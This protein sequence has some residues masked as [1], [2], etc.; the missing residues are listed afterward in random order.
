M[1]D[2]KNQLQRT[3][4][5]SYTLERELE[6]GGMARVF[7][8]RDEGLGRQVVV[9]TLADDSGVS[10]SAERFRREIRLAASLQ[11]ANIVPVHSA[12]DVDGVPYYTMPFVEGESLRAHMDKR[13]ALEVRE[14]VN[15]LRDVAR[16][17]AFAHER[18]VVHR[19]IKP[20]NILLSGSTAVVTDFGI[21]KAIEAS[22]SL[23][24]ATTLTQLGTLLGTPAYISPE[25]AA[26]D[27][28]IDHLVDIYSLGVVAYEMLAG[29]RPFA[30]TAAR[31]LLAA[32]VNEPPPP[33]AS[34]REGLPPRLASLV[35][36][37]LEK[38]PGRRPQKAEELLEALEGAL[39]AGAASS[40]SIPSIAVLPFAN[41][42]PDPADE[43]FADGLTDEIITDLSGIKSLRVIARTA[44][45]R[46][47]GTEKEPAVIAR[48]LRVRYV[49]D[50]SVRRAGNSMRLTARLLDTDTDAIVWSDKLSGNVEDVFE[51]Q[52]RVSRTIVDALKLKLS[53][54]EERH[55][56]E[57]PFEDLP[58]YQAYLQAKQAMW[59]F[60]P[61][62]LKRARE[63]LEYA[64]SRVGDN[65][66]LISALG[67]VAIHLISA[68][69]AD[70]AE[71]VARADA[72]AK[73]LARLAPDSFG[74]F[75]LQGLLHWRNGE[76]REAIST[77]TSAH[78]REPSNVDV[79]AYLEY[80]HLLA[81]RDDRARE[82]G[83]LVIALDPVTPLMQVMPT[84]CDLMAGKADQ[85]L[86][87]Y[88]EFASLEPLNPLAQ[89]WL[90]SI[91]AEGGDMRGMR[92]C[93]ID[94]RTRWPDSEF[95]LAAKLTLEILD[96]PDRATTITVPSAVRTLSSESE[97][98]SRSLTWLFGR[99]GAHDAA[100]DALEDC[101]GRG[102]AH[103]PHLA[104]DAKSLSGVRGHPRFQR[105]LS[106][107]RERWERGGTSA[108]DL[109]REQAAHAAQAAPAAPT[110]TA[111]PSIA[112]L[113]FA[114]LSPDRADEFFADGLTDEIITD[115]SGIKS[116][117]VIARSAMMRFKATE[118]E[119]AAIAREL[120]VRYVLDGS[121]RR[122]GDSMRLTARLLD[123]DTDTIVWSDKLNGK[124]E[125]VFE[126]QERVSRTIVTA[127]KVT[128]SPREERHIAERPI[129]DLQAYDA[130]LQARQLMWTF[131]TE[132]L[133]RA[134]QLLDAAHA[135]IGENPRLLAALGNLHLNYI[136]TGARDAAMHL[137]EAWKYGDRVAQ[138]EPDSFAA[139]A[140]LGGL[141]WRTGR[142]REAIVS[143]RRARE[144]EPNSVDICAFLTYA[145]LLAG[146]DDRA[147]ELSETLTKLDP[148]TPLFQVM[149]G[150]CDTMV[151]NPDA[152]V[153]YY[154]RFVEADPQSPVP[155][156]FYLSV[157]SETDDTDTTLAAAERLAREF[158]ETPFGR[159][160][161]AYARAIRGERLP[162]TDLIT[163]EIRA[164]TASSDAFA[165]PFGVLLARMGEH[166]A[167]IDALEC[168]VRLGLAH[169]PYLARNCRALEPLRS[170]PR[171][172]ALLDVVRGRWER[173]GTSA[174]D[175][176]APVASA[177][178][179]A[180]K[181]VIAVLPFANLSPDPENEFFAD[182]I[183]DD[184]IAQVAKI[185]SLRVIART[186]VMRY[187]G[188]H[189]AARTA[190]KELGV[191]AVVEGTVRRAGKRA[192]IVAQLIDAS[193]NAP[194]WSETYDRDLDDVFTVQTEVATSVA[195]ALKVNL[196]PA[197]ERRIAR[198]PTSDAKAYDLY[199]IG[200]HLFNRRTPESLR[201][202]IAQFEQAIERDPRFAAA[203]AG[204]ADAYTFAGLGYAPVPIL[205]AFASAKS[206][207]DR[208]LALDDASPEAQC[209]TGLSA[210]H[211][212]W[213][214]VRARAAFE[215]AVAL[216]PSHAAAHQMLG[217][218]TFAVGEYAAALEPLGRARELDPLNV[219]LVVEE[220]WPYMYGGLHAIGLELCRRAVTLD[221]GFGL[222]HYNVG[223]CLEALGRHAE[224]LA[225]FER[226][227]ECMGPSPWMLAS[228]GT[229]SVA[230]GNP[231]RA[232]EVLAT[233][234]EQGRAGV[235][236][237]L[238]IA[239]VHDALGEAQPG[240]DALERSIEAHEP[241]V[242]AL[243]LENWLKFPNVRK[244]PG[245]SRLYERVGS[246]PHNIA[247]QRE[248]LLAHA[249]QQGLA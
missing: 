52:E 115:L 11:Q 195:A 246:K 33:L 73:K 210:M 169:Y 158:P 204:L 136:E 143:L 186:S 105:I 238:S 101:V 113:P 59:S 108:E 141:Q 118:K 148:I 235:A 166:D 249:K 153:P 187:R 191:S 54:R 62:S 223:N 10:V 177:P 76:V 144:L 3:L 31:A 240:L 53:P 6:G 47:K 114:N 39:L 22:H 201:G 194:I 15:I 206:A 219:S 110:A 2:L 193:S 200:R 218:C 104:R 122:A 13:G 57:R 208:A 9:K 1:S 159:A 128:L 182:G 216:N 174:E 16:A 19:D 87:K 224:A 190:A 90:L 60:G 5:D 86:D 156:Y 103:Y 81:G 55:L 93:A 198:S 199:L 18:G 214:V 72:S 165:R 170:L 45:M 78:E 157:L 127:L 38:D 48:E 25:Q 23:A 130:Y 34:K 116:L 184:L 202:A 167:A 89:F 145:Y 7:V 51:M 151:G 4:G 46:F 137:A 85:V 14:A 44:M 234:H 129:A 231:A 36:R 67:F 84:F 119:P 139:H 124:V 228:V 179:I 17:L 183:T 236:V 63:L 121:V 243:G 82:L 123:T 107:V 181:P 221:P 220:A 66:A 100:L 98:I 203:H 185:G 80:S 133:D 41:L 178:T 61:A 40:S 102:L 138:L 132:S 28:N 197:E 125:D 213:D 196:T 134:R 26:G 146:Q 172:R 233:L 163:D 152:A 176:A 142:I 68:G 205:E 229:V 162:I 180:S 232:R 154:R 79:V 37:C 75:A 211:G 74:R 109:V 168:S 149:T 241:F 192:R 147:R 30:A 97:S 150:Y 126:M 112:V 94:I 247:R 117:R 83:Q 244:L 20:E 135:R 111:L 77:L 227:V 239:I 222:G 215:R 173:G 237:W 24:G 12:G 245:F 65:P 70:I 69:G 99:L 92:E 95:G 96:H 42:S 160:A 29:A 225:C 212:D 207:A 209:A 35:M 49:L 155:H 32:H 140:L 91:R 175:L 56:S 43:F 230:L 106:I 164:V 21:A 27:P 71:E 58:A 171:F 120:R 188:A 64:I 226:A 242:W 8:A 189:D 217:W 161:H 131:T 88:T 50:G 248:L